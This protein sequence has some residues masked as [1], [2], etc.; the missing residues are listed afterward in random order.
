M[1]P[2][3]PV[4]WKETL[5]YPMIGHPIA[6]VKSP[7]T[8]NRYFAE[9][10]IDA[11]MIPIDV[12][13]SEVVP[14]FSFLRGW[15]NCPGCIVTMP[16][17]Q[18]SF[19]Q[20]DE[21]SDRARDLGA[22][23]VI[24]RTDEGRLV[25]DMVDGLG[26]LEALHRNGFDVKEKRA[27]VF[28]AG[29]AGSAIAYSIAQAGAAELAIVDTDIHRQKRL[30]ELIASRSPSVL[31]SISVASLAEFDLAVNATPIGMT[32][33]PRMPFPLDTLQST[34]FV[35]DVVTEPEM[36]PWLAGAKERGCRTQTGYEMTLGQFAIMGRHMGIAID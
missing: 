13:P 31:L 18:E 28:G 12:L 19:R 25:G 15:R 4:S 7:A 34:T 23:N 24:R 29:G 26:F 21:L 16:H 27:V 32:G 8:F 2:D 6:Q 10:K 1:T 20:A 22:V 33:D 5:V 30:R 14:F 36:T 9:K 11:V 35:A 3:Q 17:K